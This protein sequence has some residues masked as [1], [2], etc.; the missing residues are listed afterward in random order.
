VKAAPDVVVASDGIAWAT[1]QDNR[2]GGGDVYV[3]SLGPTATAWTTNTKVSDDSTTSGIDKSPRIGLTSAGSPVVAYLDGRATNAAVRVVNR[4]GTTW[5]ASLQV[6]DASAKPATGLALAVKADGGIIVA[7]D[8]TRV[9]ATAIWGA[10]C[11]A[12]SGTSSVTRCGPTE[13]W[14]DQAGASTHPTLIASTTKVYLGWSDA[15]AGNLD[16]RVRLRNPS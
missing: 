2:T 14:S 16:I 10:Q 8:D 3:A 13:K 9:T 5:N 4:N 6:S 1:W 15:T 12:G 7:W 11:E